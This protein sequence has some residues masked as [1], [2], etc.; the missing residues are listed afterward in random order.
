MYSTTHRALA[1]EIGRIFTSR[2]N[3]QLFWR[4]AGPYDM[5]IL[6]SFHVLP[7]SCGERVAELSGFGSAL[8][9]NP[10]P[11]DKALAGVGRCS[12]PCGASSI[13]E[14]PAFVDVE[15]GKHELRN[16]VPEL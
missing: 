7:P 8:Y 3:R 4:T 2:A 14:R 1:R 10:L 12:S 11:I 16:V 15:V 9:S 5:S 6:N 13:A